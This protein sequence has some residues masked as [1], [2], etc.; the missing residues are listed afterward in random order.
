ML[1][2]SLF[3]AFSSK[4]KYNLDFLFGSVVS[5][6][7]GTAPI[8]PVSVSV[9]K[10]KK[11]RETNRGKTTSIMLQG[12]QILNFKCL[13]LGKGGSI[14]SLDLDLDIKLG[15]FHVTAPIQVGIN[16][17]AKYY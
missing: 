7:L 4:E 3:L 16:R 2:L 8:N 12:T 11:V 9:K 10:K 13:V 1:F 5:S 6:L 15:L 17:T 14:L